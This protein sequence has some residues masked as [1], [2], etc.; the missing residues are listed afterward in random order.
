M[1]LDTFN[2]VIEH[3]PSKLNPADPISRMEERYERTD[4]EWE[5]LEDVTDDDHHPLLLTTANFDEWAS[6]ET[7]GDAN[8]PAIYANHEVL[9]DLVHGERTHA[10]HDAATSFETMEM[11]ELEIANEQ[12]KDAEIVM[13]KAWLRG[14]R[15]IEK[16]ELRGRGKRL[17][18]LVEKK[19]RL[20]L[21]NNLLVFVRR[22]DVSNVDRE[23]IVIPSH[24]EGRVVGEFHSL[25]HF[26][27]MKLRLT[28]LQH[29]WMY[30]L[31]AKVKVCVKACEN[32]QKRMGPHRK[33]KLALTNQNA[34]FF[35]EKII[36][37]LITMR[38]S[39][40]G[41]ES[42]LSIVNVWSGFAWCVAIKNGSTTEVAKALTKEWISRYGVPMEIQSDGGGEFTSKLMNELCKVWQV[43]K[44]VASPYAPFSSGKVE[45][46]NKTVKDMVAKELGENL[47]RWDEVLP[48]VCFYYNST[49]QLT[50][51]FS[52]FELLTGTLPTL[53]A[54]ATW[55]ARP[56]KKTHVEHVD[57]LMER[58]R[59]ISKGVYENTRQNQATM[60]RSFNK[61]VHGKPLDVGDLVRVHYKGPAASGVTTKL[62]SRWR[63]PYRVME[64]ISDKVYVVL[65]PH[66]GEMVPRIQNFRNLWKVGHVIGEKE[67]I[68]LEGGIEPEW[69]GEEISAENGDL[70]I[71]GSDDSDD[72]DINDENDDENGGSGAPAEGNDPGTDE[73]IGD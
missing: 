56:E 48:L 47:R 67:E 12:D 69:D 17:R 58:M 10:L 8:G 26:G 33:F 20:K 32:C 23:L 18:S 60:Q 44:I 45:R 52:P 68:D 59:R 50:T 24:L 61:K 6:S 15:N 64:K 65:M 72:D 29:V 16:E 71:E 2:Y 19:E 49:V 7:A 27:E 30:D 43:E 4:E 51:G 66:R 70:G 35:N 40:K 21:K 37:D 62:I 46:F 55:E 41:N 39:E 28:L 53:P 1:F 73:C 63:G 13:V 31:K 14:E 38:P 42:A 54:L 5:R 3:V 25:G 57:E 36:L 34:G 22:E 11:D 9:E